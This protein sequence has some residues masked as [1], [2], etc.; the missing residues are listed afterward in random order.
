MLI[1][2]FLVEFDDFFYQSLIFLIIVFLS[3]ENWDISEHKLSNEKRNV[4]MQNNGTHE[5]WF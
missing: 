2:C 3:L 4:K 5:V 1:T